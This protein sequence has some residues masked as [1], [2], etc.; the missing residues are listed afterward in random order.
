MPSKNIIRV[1]E[2]EKLYYDNA[3]PFKQKHW[4]ALCNYLENV[5]KKEENRI[6]Y[7][8]IL[9][10]GIQF[11]NYVGVIQAGNLTVEILP[12]VDKG[13]TTA[14]NK[15]IE[16][17]EEKISREKQQWHHVLLQMLKECRLLK[18]NHVDYAN[19]NL[20]S[21]SILDIYIELFLEEAERLLH[22]GLLK[23][24]QKKEG[25]QTALKG[26]LQFSKQIAYNSTHGERFYIRYTEY[27]R[28][29]IYNQLIYKTVQLIPTISNN[30][31]LLDKVSRLLLDFP[32]VTN[33]MVNTDTFYHLQFDRKTERYKEALLISKMLLLN[34]RPDITGGTENVIAILF[35]MNKL[36]EEFVYRRLKKEEATTNITVHRQQ[37]SNF[38]KPDN[39]NYSKK[40]RPDI[41]LKHKEGGAEQII[42]VDTKWKI[43]QDLTSS[44]EDLKQMF[45]YNLFWKCDRSIL[46]YPALKEEFA[47]GKYYDYNKLEAFGS[48]CS[49]L[50]ISI[51]DKSELDKEFGKKII[52]KIKMK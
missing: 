40:I 24:Y 12:K 5:N 11:T 10:N 36:W 2:F 51:L 3:K 6:E 50:T 25:N 32:E 22:E 8:R 14:A 47:S 29:N 31:Y 1:S 17:L 49:A 30:T 9:K 37:S 42:V 7:F 46:L 26:Q 45:V 38:W 21:N 16:Q 52:N 28:N 13:N 41:V 23:K 48:L 18:V 19:L 39:S 35:D 4:A 44:D 34:Y 43:L 20:R 15:S 33:C 27:N